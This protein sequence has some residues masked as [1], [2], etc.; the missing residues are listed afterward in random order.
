[1]MPERESFGSKNSLCPRS[2]RSS[3]PGLAGGCSA[4]SGSGWKSGDTPGGREPLVATW[5][6]APGAPLPQP[7]VAISTSEA[8]RSTRVRP[9][10]RAAAAARGGRFVGLVF[11]NTVVMSPLSVSVPDPFLRRDLHPAGEGGRDRASGEQL[12]RSEQ[13][14]VA[15]KRRRRSGKGLQRRKRGVARPGARGEPPVAQGGPARSAG[16]RGLL[17]LRRGLLRRVA[18]RAEEEHGAGEPLADREQERPVHAHRGR[19]GLHA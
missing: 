19:R 7:I 18:D 2:I 10:S 13:A 4:V 14:A 5:S 16:R 12:I 6:S 11:R 8:P 1:M 17:R 9:P 3:V 15:G